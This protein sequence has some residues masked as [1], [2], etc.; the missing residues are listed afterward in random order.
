MLHQI[1]EESGVE[2]D[3][4]TLQER[5]QRAFTQ[6]TESYIKHNTSA[7]REIPGASAF[8]EHL[9][10]I[11]DVALAIATG[12]W[13]STAEL[14]LRSIGLNPDHF[15]LATASDAISRKEII[16]IAADR[17]LR[18]TEA[19]RKTYFGDGL[20]DKKTSEAL[21]Y[22][23]IGVGNRVE[24]HTTYLDYRDVMAICARLGV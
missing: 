24:H 15:A 9:Q 20:W 12:G 16:E 8:I 23:F 19:V 14:K 17:S 1:I 18:G 13:N 21:G 4:E 10:Q 22:D 6:L 5:V 11:E 2:E 3:R 7:V